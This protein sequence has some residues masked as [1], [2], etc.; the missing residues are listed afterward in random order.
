MASQAASDVAWIDDAQISE[1]LRRDFPMHY[2]AAQGDTKV[3]HESK[4]HRALPPSV[5]L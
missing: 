3:R 5:F 2:A 1:T 4:V